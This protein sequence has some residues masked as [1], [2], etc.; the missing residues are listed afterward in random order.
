MLP[1]TALQR[2][3]V[4]SPAR[5]HDNP[6]LDVQFVA[7]NTFRPPF[8]EVRVRRALNYAIDRRAIARM[9]GL[10]A[11]TPTCHPLVPGLSGY[12]PYC[13]YTRRPRRD[14]RWSAPNPALARRLVAASGTRGSTVAVSAATDLPGIPARLPAYVAGVLRSLGC[15]THLH[16]VPYASFSPQSRRRLQL[17]VDGDWV[18]DYPAPG[19][20]LP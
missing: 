12:R 13:P 16:L 10:S 1:T 5:L 2:L 20:Y 8:D 6:T 4:E 15:R 18:P 7:L 19:S 9:F 3:R 14:G 11:A 17:T